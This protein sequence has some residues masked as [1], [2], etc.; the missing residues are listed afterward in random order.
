MTVAQPKLYTLTE[1]LQLPE[2][3]PASE[4]INGQIFQKPMP[5][6][7][8]SRLQLKLCTAINQ[9][10]EATAVALALPELRC[11]FS[12][13]SFV[14][15]IAVFRWERI[16]FDADGEVSNTFEAAPDWVIEILSPGQSQTKLTDKMLFCLQHGA[17]LGWLIDP[18]ERAVICYRPNGLPSIRRGVESLPVLAGVELSLTVEALFGWLKPENSSKPR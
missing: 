8:H 3:E 16:P 1:F 5:K 9:I 15:D 13:R 18:E 14:P 4:F 7:K 11:T 12:E 17:Q 2:T 6:G 10:T